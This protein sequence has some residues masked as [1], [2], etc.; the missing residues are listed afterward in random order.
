M[1]RSDFWSCKALLEDMS[2]YLLRNFN[3]PK[4]YFT[5]SMVRNSDLDEIHFEWFNIK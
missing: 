3:I 1:E 4:I 2:F 5:L